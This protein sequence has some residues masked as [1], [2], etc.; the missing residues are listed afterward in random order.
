ME[1]A[2]ISP[3]VPRR[4]EGSGSV[5][6]FI[7]PLHYI[8]SGQSHV[9]AAFSPGSSEQEIRRAQETGCALWRTEKLLLPEIEPS[10]HK[11]VPRHLITTLTKLFS[12]LPIRV[13]VCVIVLK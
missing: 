11:C 4:V 8:V 5:S 6:S 13:M 1:D 7:L 2:G 3:F 12:W 9:L 10:F